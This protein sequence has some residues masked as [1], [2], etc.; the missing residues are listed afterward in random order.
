LP[1]LYYRE[2]LTLAVL[3]LRESGTLE[4]LKKDWWER[5][6]ECPQDEEGAVSLQYQYKYCLLV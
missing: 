3:R 1:C 4:E 6:T 5:K 2:A